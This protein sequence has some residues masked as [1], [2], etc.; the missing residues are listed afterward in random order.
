MFY[1]ILI[2]SL[3]HFRLNSTSIEIKWAKQEKDI[4]KQLATLV[5]MPRYHELARKKVIPM[6]EDI[7][8]M[9]EAAAILVHMKLSDSLINPMNRLDVSGQ[10]TLPPN[11]LTPLVEG[12]PSPEDLHPIENAWESDH[13]GLH[14]NRLRLLP[15]SCTPTAMDERVARDWFARNMDIGT[16]A[17]AKSKSLEQSPNH[18]RMSVNST[19]ETWNQANTHFQS[20]VSCSSYNAG[21]G[22]AN[23]NQ[24]EAIKVEEAPKPR[25]R[26]CTYCGV[27]G[28]PI[29]SCPMVPCRRCHTIGHASKNCPLIPCK[30]CN[31]TGQHAVGHC[32][33]FL[34]K[35]AQNEQLR[36]IKRAARATKK[37]PTQEET[38]LKRPLAD[39]SED[40]ANLVSIS[41]QQDLEKET[42]MHSPICDQPSHQT[43]SRTNLPCGYCHATGHLPKNCPVAK[44][45][46]NERERTSSA[47]Q[48]KKRGRASR[49]KEETDID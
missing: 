4:R 26:L 39:I 44:A 46:K 12:I 2:Y 34:A 36:S 11:T 17:S 6:T 23:Q 8:T 38:S 32:P 1:S 19:T 5:N 14:P 24:P 47:Q 30:Y 41:G 25:W 37:K 3:Y 31:C 33:V 45:D 42:R 13:Q 22:L 49:V 27:P 16:T 35:M 21:A 9:E 43:R 48:R 40:Y 20:I 10:P 29:G 7:M 15:K 18:D 28:H